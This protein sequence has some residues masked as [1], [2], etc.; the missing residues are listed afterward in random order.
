MSNAEFETLNG[1]TSSIQTQLDTKAAAS[2]LSTK[3]NQ[4]TLTVASAGSS[5]LTLTTGGSY[6]NT[7]TYTPPALTGYALKTGATFTGDVLFDG[8]DVHVEGGTAGDTTLF[9][10]GPYASPSFLRTSAQSDGRYFNCREGDDET[11]T[12]IMSM[13]VIGGNHCYWKNHDGSDWWVELTDG[14]RLKPDTHNA[15]DIGSNTTKWEDIYATNGEI[16]DSDRTLKQEI[17]PLSLQEVGAATALSKLFCTYRWKS[18]VVA[19]GDAARTHT[20]IIAQDVEDVMNSFGLNALDYSILC[21]GTHYETPAELDGKAYT[22]RIETNGKDAKPLPEGAVEFT[23]YSLRYQ[24][25]MCF[26]AAGTEHR[27]AAIE[28]RLAA[29]E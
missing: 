4:L 21:K 8:G 26:I 23:S 13:G 9:L 6:L 16:Q 14:G 25:L 17:T 22:R 10:I 15:R 24:E 20:G 28:A 5:N 27:L 19:K 11:G 2:T 12:I 3:Q 1:V 18:A 29:L 7:L